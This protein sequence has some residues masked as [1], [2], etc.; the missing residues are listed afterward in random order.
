MTG[1]TVLALVLCFPSNGSVGLKLASK[2]GQ[3]SIRNGGGGGGTENGGGPPVLFLGDECC[4]RF[5]LSES[6]K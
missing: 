4:R 6:I 5:T 3:N 2:P 1:K